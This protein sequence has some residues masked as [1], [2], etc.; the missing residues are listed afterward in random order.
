M[1]NQK[2]TRK[3]QRFFVFRHRETGLY[4]REGEKLWTLNIELAHLFLADG[5]RIA[6]DLMPEL[7]PTKIF[8]IDILEVIPK[9]NGTVTFN[10]ERSVK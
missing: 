5:D 2:F 3:E 4:I 10:I 6:I 7:G 9:L 1:N 8:D